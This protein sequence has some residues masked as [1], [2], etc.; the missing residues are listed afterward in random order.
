MHTCRDCSYWNRDKKRNVSLPDTPIYY[1][2]CEYA[3]DDIILPHSVVVEE[4]SEN[5]AEG[6]PIFVAHSLEGTNEKA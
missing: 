5:A 3:F 1:A 2:A 4:M 6:C